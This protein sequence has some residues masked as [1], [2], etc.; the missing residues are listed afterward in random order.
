MQTTVKLEN[1]PR[2]SLIMSWEINKLLTLTLTLGLAEADPNPVVSEF[3]LQ[4]S[5]G[6]TFKASHMKY[7]EN[8]DLR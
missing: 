1:G 3:T 7:L 8:Y 6:N 4:S 2:Y 5:K